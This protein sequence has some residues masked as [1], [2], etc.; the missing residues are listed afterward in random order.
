LS[1]L[2]PWVPIACQ[3]FWWRVFEVPLTLRAV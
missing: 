1:I 3:G 2:L